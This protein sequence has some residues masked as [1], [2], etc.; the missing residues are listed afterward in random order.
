VAFDR[1]GGFHLR[2]ISS[3]G[4][5]SSVTLPLAKNNGNDSNDSEDD[6]HAQKLKKGL[7]MIRKRINRFR[8][9]VFDNMFGS[10]GIL[11]NLKGILWTARFFQIGNASHGKENWFCQLLCWL[12]IND[13]SEILATENFRRR[14]RRRR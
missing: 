11:S 14:R 4:L 1:F 9:D 6:D 10:I 5:V 7:K 3:I 13:V 12:V 2:S 8:L